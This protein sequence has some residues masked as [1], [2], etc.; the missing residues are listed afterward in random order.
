MIKH[1]ILLSVLAIAL[2]LVPNVPAFGSALLESAKQ[3]FQAKRFHA[4][5]DSL[6]Q[7]LQAEPANPEGYYW[8]GRAL[9]ELKDRDGAKTMYMSAFKLNPFGPHAAISKKALMDLATKEAALNHPTD[10]PEVTAQTLQLIERQAADWKRM[11]VSEGNMNADWKLRSG[12][13]QAYKM[14]YRRGP[15]QLDHIP[16]PIGPTAPIQSINQIRAQMAAQ[17]TAGNPYLNPVNPYTAVN[18]YNN[19]TYDNW[20][21]YQPNNQGTYYQPGGTAG[22]MPQMGTA[23]GA[24]AAV[25]FA[26]MRVYGNREVS[27]QARINTS[28]IRNDSM[29]QGMKAQQQGVQSAAELQKSANNLESLLGEKPRAGSPHLRALGTN[30]F[31]RNYSDHDDDSTPPQDPPL[32]L[33]AKQEKLSDLDQGLHAKALKLTP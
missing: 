10:G 2:C 29:V 19:R 31:V 18:P 7:V 16:L 12:D 30:L 25:P 24:P 23:F 28:W 6:N 27:N 9:E 8:L 20:A 5:A 17:G 4:A 3:D 1:T 26:P 13:I 11:K 15:S 32:E 33:K 21:G 14:G 22:Y